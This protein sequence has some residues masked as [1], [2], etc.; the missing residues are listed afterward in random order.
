MAATG[1]LSPLARLTSLRLP[2]ESLSRPDL[3]AAMNLTAEQ[4]HIASFEGG[5]L[6]VLHFRLESRPSFQLY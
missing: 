2:R 4:L 6:T 5:R 1:D 3:R